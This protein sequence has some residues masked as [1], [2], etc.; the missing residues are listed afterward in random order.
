MAPVWVVGPGL[1]VIRRG[2][3]GTAA[4]GNSTEP[5]AARFD[6]GL[7]YGLYR[8][9]QVNPNFGR[10][11]DATDVSSA[12]GTPSQIWDCTGGANQQWNTP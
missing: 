3:S 5:G 7:V 4:A 2:W 12:D 6:M 9:S 1:G 11:L 10:C 8:C